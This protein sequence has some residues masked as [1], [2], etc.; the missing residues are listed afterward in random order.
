MQKRQENHMPNHH[1]EDAKEASADLIQSAPLAEPRKFKNTDWDW[2]E[3]I[4]KANAAREFGK[5]LRKGKPIIF[6]NK[7]I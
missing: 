5:E 3:R 7:V 2:K 4:D 6:R 1:N